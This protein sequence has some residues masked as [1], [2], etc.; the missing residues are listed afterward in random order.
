MS[1]TILPSQSLS[2]RFIALML[3]P[4]C[5]MSFSLTRMIVI[6]KYRQ[7]AEQRVQSETVRAA[8]SFRLWPAD[9]RN[10]SNFTQM[11]DM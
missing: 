6:W 4:Q 10:A 5:V 9:A 11:C 3:E 7:T 2:F 1:A 8:Q